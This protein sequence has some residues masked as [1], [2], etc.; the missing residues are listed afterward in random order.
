[1]I[2]IDSPKNGSQALSFIILVDGTSGPFYRF[3]SVGVQKSGLISLFP[4]PKKSLNRPMNPLEE[5]PMFRCFPPSLSMT[6]LL[7]TALASGTLAAPYNGLG[8]GSST[9][10]SGGDYANL[11]AAVAAINANPLTGGDWTFTITS[12]FTDPNPI[13][14]YTPTNGNTIF[15]RPADDTAVTVTLSTTADNVAAGGYAGSF[16]IGT[17]ATNNLNLNP[18]QMKVVIDGTNN[19]GPR[20]LGFTNV[21]GM[22]DPLI[23]F[24][25]NTAESEIKNVT[26]HHLSTTTGNNRICLWLHVQANATD[27]LSPNDMV[28][29]NVH[30]IANGNRGAGLRISNDGTATTAIQGLIVRSNL[31]QVRRHG[32]LSSSLATGDIHDNIFQLVASGT[33]TTWDNIGMEFEVAGAFT[34]NC[35][36]W[37]NRIYRN[38]IE[39][40]GDA[41]NALSAVVGIW[42]VSS[43][44]NPS[45]LPTYRIFNNMISARFVTAGGTRTSLGC[46]GISIEGTHLNTFVEHNSI[47][48]RTVQGNYNATTLVPARNFALGYLAEDLAGSHVVRNNIFYSEF[49]QSSS[50]V[51]LEFQTNA[52]A[53]FAMNNNNLFSTNV[54]S[55]TGRYGTGTIAAPTYATATSLS[56]WQTATSLDG[57]SVAVN[58]LPGSGQQWALSGT[59][60]LPANLR[61][62]DTATAPPLPLVGVATSITGITTDIDN[63]TRFS[64]KPTMGADEIPG[65][66][67]PVNMSEFALE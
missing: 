1:L 17:P 23:R 14:L 33:N 9:I 34:A 20:R 41:N 55:V 32:I 62:A 5:H 39:V 43:G 29:E 27:T 16:L 54:I 53:S 67:V 51:N 40:N 50:V 10:G 25:G 44:A 48:L 7:L 26:L 35:A 13:A 36:S 59:W 58:P 19:L 47:R 56:D 24:I 2:S 31:F 65:L 57:A 52:P 46:R 60:A 61:W 42:L 45:N 28:I 64:A 18:A 63:E 8:P 38:Q 66:P 37:D 6:G 11:S 21:S 12:S 30:F 22:P 4:H 3:Q 15:F 49:G